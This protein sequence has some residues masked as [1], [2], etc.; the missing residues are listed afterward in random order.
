MIATHDSSLTKPTSRPPYR[1]QKKPE[2]YIKPESLRY[3]RRGS[4]DKQFPSVASRHASDTGPGTMNRDT[5]SK[6]FPIWLIADSSPARWEKHLRQPLDPRHPAR[7]NIWTPILEGIQGHV[8]QAARSRIDTADLYIR[9]AVHNAADKPRYRRPDWLSSVADETRCLSSLLA[10][11]RPRLLVT[12]GA[13]AYEFTRRS[14]DRSP[15]RAVS[16]WTS[17]KL[18]NE[19]RR[20]VEAFD[21]MR[22]AIL[23]LLH[24]SI[25]RGRFL[26]NHRNFTGQDDANYFDYAAHSIAA[27]LLAHRD[28]FAV[29]Q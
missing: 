12:F 17:I 5:G 28:E 1:G 4:R 19:F 23:P 24:V 6:A 29:W 11:H 9:N 3:T 7:H 18:G 16:H 20:C 8:F 26:Q 22:I 10:R 25:A 14:L 2:A 27:L 13:F 15:P 21:P